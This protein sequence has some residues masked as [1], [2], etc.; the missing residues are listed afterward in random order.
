MKNARTHGEETALKEIRARLEAELKALDRELRV[1][2]PK[3]IQFARE[4]GDLRENAEYKAALERQSHVRGRIA[5]IQQRLSELSRINLDALPTD[6]VHLGSRVTVLDLD[7]DVESVYEIVVAEGAEADMGQISPASPIGRGL[8]GKM[9]GDEVKINVPSGAR[10]LE[11]VALK[12]IHDL[13]GDGDST[14]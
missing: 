10:S 14:S 4:L 12:T 13:S 1:E 6:R 2:L 5:Q 9:V 8:I 7:S 3:E 11:I